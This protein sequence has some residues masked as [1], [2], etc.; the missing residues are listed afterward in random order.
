VKNVTDEERAF[1]CK[2]PATLKS[3]RVS[4]DSSIGEWNRRRLFLR[5]RE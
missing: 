5:K 3:A 1:N 2:L 4:A